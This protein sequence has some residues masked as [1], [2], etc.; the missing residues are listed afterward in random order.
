MNQR[1]RDGRILGFRRRRRRRPGKRDRF[2]GGFLRVCEGRR[3]RAG[4]SGH[5]NVEGIVH[6]SSLTCQRIRFSFF[7][8]K[9]KYNR[10]LNY[11]NRYK[12][13]PSAVLMMI[14]TDVV[15]TWPVLLILVLRD[16][17][18]TLEAKYKKIKIKTKHRAHMS[19]RQKKKVVGPTYQ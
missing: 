11:Q 7:N 18:V 16:S 12:A 5:V 17:D 9:I 10:F 4:E 15:S 1:L 8:Q 3:F 19:V 13:G 14:L 2:G 6:F